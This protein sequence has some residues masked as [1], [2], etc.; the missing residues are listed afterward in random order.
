[1]FFNVASIANMCPFSDTIGS[2]IISIVI[3]IYKFRLSLLEILK[4]NKDH[5]CSLTIWYIWNAINDQVSKILVRDPQEILIFAENEAT[6]WD[7]ATSG[8][9]D[10][11]SSN[12][13][14]HPMCFLTSQGTVVSLMAPG[15]RMIFSG[16]GWYYFQ[17]EVVGK[18]M[19]V[20]NLLIILSPLQFELE[21]FIWILH[22]MLTKQKTTVAF[23][24]DCSN[25][26]KMVA[27]WFVFSVYLEEF[28]RR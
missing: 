15:M 1:M 13:L 16:L 7:E 6:L 8:W 4:E 11:R 26:V 20:R 23:A 21:S 25:L 3:G 9:T 17:E 19:G 12:M 22:W 2:G 10:F 27:D 28:G 24:I 5:N 18:I 14:P